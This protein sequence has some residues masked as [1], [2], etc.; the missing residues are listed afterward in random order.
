MSNDELAVRLYRDAH[1]E[2]RAPWWTVVYGS[3]GTRRKYSCIACGCVIDTESANYPQTKHAREACDEH[4]ESC[5]ARAAW[6]RAAKRIAAVTAARGLVA[7]F[8]ADATRLR[9]ALNLAFLSV[10][11]PGRKTLLT[12][13]CVPAWIATLASIHA[14]DEAL[15]REVELTELVSAA[16]SVSVVQP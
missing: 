7:V 2:S 16:V 9:G 1:R 8:G 10:V 3:G 4:D 5:A 13:Y 12:V 11:V 15:K 6:R 14:S